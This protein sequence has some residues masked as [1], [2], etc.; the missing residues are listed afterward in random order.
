[1]SKSCIFCGMPIDSDIVC[2]KCDKIQFKDSKTYQ[3]TAA[4]SKNKE[5]AQ[6]DILENILL[7]E[8]NSSGESITLDS[9]ASFILLENAA[10]QGDVGALVLLG[11][12]Y[13]AG[14]TAVYADGHLHLRPSSR[15]RPDRR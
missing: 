10:R 15:Y 2:L 6:D 14:R 11:Q 9:T 5:T 13:L 12:Q 4:F 3:A 7:E 8:A 1:M